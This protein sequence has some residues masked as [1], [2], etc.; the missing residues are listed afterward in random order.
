[1]HT[2]DMAYITQRDDTWYDIT[3][4][5]SNNKQRGNVSSFSVV[6]DCWMSYGLGRGGGWVLS[7]SMTSSEHVSGVPDG[8]TSHL[9]LASEVSRSDDAF[10]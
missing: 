10:R 4:D 6:L 3:Q 2:V 1:M 5:G 8:S 7:T 9:L